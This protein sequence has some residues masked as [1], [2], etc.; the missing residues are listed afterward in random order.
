VSGQP[1]PGPSDYDAE[2]RLH[3]EVL[4]RAYDVQ[5]WHHLLDIGCGTGQTTRDVARMARAG[6]A[7]GIDIRASART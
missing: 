1:L 4:R 6:S 5:R 7:S 2:L 3:D